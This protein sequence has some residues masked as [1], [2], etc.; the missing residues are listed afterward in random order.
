M[1]EVL[2]P[3]LQEIVVL[4]LI[5]PWTALVVARLFNCLPWASASWTPF[6]E[7]RKCSTSRVKRASQPSSCITLNQA[8]WNGKFKSRSENPSQKN[9]KTDSGE[10]CSAFGSMA[11]ACFRYVFMNAT[12]AGSTLYDKDITI[13]KLQG[14]QGL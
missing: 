5:N 2:L 8:A 9:G 11:L 10:E 7:G 1:L 14:Q 12:I 3:S 6:C 4:N 13:F